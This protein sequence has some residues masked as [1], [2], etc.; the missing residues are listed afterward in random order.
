[1]G[2]Q[3]GATSEVV[4]TMQK[5]TLSRRAVTLAPLWLA[6]LTACKPIQPDANRPQAEAILEINKEISGTNNMTNTIL[7]PEGVTYVRYY[8]G[9]DG[10]SHFGEVTIGL[11]PIEMPTGPPVNFSAFTPA[12]HHFFLHL[13][14]GYSHDWLPVSAR[15]LWCHIFGE[16]EITVSDGETRRVPA[17]SVV[18][19]ED[20]TG[21]GH[22]ARVVGD[23]D[24]L[25]SGVEFSE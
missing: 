24:V 3:L 18:L 17:G 16:M 14:A 1:M 8:A 20:T 4:K 21:K 5:V 7:T 6:F 23:R 15:S 25:L 19:A 2:T 11:A 10:E 13:P 22:R 12:K 9:T